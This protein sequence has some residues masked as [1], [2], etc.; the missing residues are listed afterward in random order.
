ML[1]PAE[2]I[3]E[4]TPWLKCTGY[5]G[6]L[7]GRLLDEI[8]Q[9]YQ[10]PNSGDE[11]ELAAICASVSRL[12]T[13]GMSLLDKD[14]GKEERRLSKVNAKLLNTFRRAE[15]SQDPI[16]PLQNS[17]SRQKYIQTWQKLLCYSY[18]VTR[19]KYLYREGQ[20][21]FQQTQ[22]QLSSATTAWEQAR[23]VCLEE[24][25]DKGEEHN[26][27]DQAVLHLSLSLIQ[28]PLE[29]RAFDSAIVSFAAVLAWDTAKKTWKDVN[30]YTSF[31]SQIIYNCQLIVLLHCLDL[32]DRRRAGTLTSCLKEERDRWL[33]NDTTGPVA[34]LSANRLLG[35]TIGKAMV[36]QAQVRWHADQETIVFQEVQLHMDQLKELVVYELKGATAILEKDLC[37][38]IKDI[39]VYDAR[40]LVDNWDAASPGQSFLTDTRNSSYIATGQSWL[41]NQLKL[42]PEV[43]KQLYISTSTPPT[44]ARPWKLSSTAV[45]AYEGAV[46]NFLEHMMVLLHIT[47][48]QPARR[49]E[50]LGL[51]WCNKQADKR[52][53]FIHDGYLLF[54]LR[55]HKSL[56]MTNSSRFPARFMLAKVAELLLQYLILVQ[57]LRI[58]FSVETGLPKYVSEYLWHNGSAIW[59]EDRMT[60]V[61]LAHSTQAIGVRLNIQAWRQIAVGIAIKKFSRERLQLDLDIPADGYAG[62]EGESTSNSGGE[63]TGSMPEAFH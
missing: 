35:F 50:F 40:G 27:L 26:S 54:L 51:R 12:L 58:W 55:Y 15:M 22:E 20:P 16:K 38:G 17:Q 3:S 48:G 11:P 8:L 39:P 21:P 52:N 2:H 19:D 42:K 4:L 62:P 59:T 18:R 23:Q 49:P 24:E 10:L 37:F 44:S 32:V 45:T 36:N 53:V 6:H 33:L 5:A 56:N 34:E 14:E 46:Q 30:N 25:D 43:L 31:L 61:L 41:F 29:R 60:R 13:K 28:H 7:E 63:A 47:S 1:E 57:P 9:A